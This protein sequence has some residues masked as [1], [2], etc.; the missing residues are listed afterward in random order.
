MITPG[1]SH[2]SGLDEK[3]I[4]CVRDA[5]AASQPAPR[6]IVPDASV[7]P[8]FAELQDGKGLGADAALQEYVASLKLRYAVFVTPERGKTQRT[9]GGALHTDGGAVIGLG[10]TEW[11]SL[12]GLVMDLSS[13][14]PIGS[15]RADTKAESGTVFTTVPF[16]MFL[17]MSQWTRDGKVCVDFGREVAKL[18]R[19]DFP[20]SLQD[21]SRRT[22]SPKSSGTTLGRPGRNG[23]QVIY[24]ISEELAFTTALD[25]YAVLYPKQSVDDIVEG[26][27]RGYDAEEGASMDWWSHRLLVIPA[28]GTDANGKEVHGYWY[29]YLGTGSMRPTEERQ[30]ALIKLIRARLDATGTAVKV[31]NLR[32]GQYETDG[33]GYLGLKRDAGDIRPEAAIRK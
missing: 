10:H 8:A 21:D 29:D 20:V 12:S 31:T 7:R 1:E 32:D 25:A 30:T 26:Q 15:L 17:W 23:E 16:P 5:L 18:L 3:V 28:I 24:Q 6:V 13:G 4:S 11:Y 9:E 2:D 22:R 27:R 19:D 14:L 33:Q